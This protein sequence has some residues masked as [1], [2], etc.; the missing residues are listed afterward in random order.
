MTNTL[1]ILSEL[2]ANNQDFEWYPTTDIMIEMVFAAAGDFSSILDIGAGDGRVLERLD[3]LKFERRRKRRIAEGD[4]PEDFFSSIEKYAIE[5]SLVH[6]EKMPP[7]ISIVGTDFNLQVLLDKKVDTIFCNPPYTEYE[8]WATKIIKEANAKDIFLILPDRWK[9]S[10]LIEK[11]VELRGAFSRVIWSGDFM[12]A[13]RQ[14]RARV[15]IIKVC[16]SDTRQ[17]DKTD[18]FHVW[19]DEYFPEFDKIAPHKDDDDDEDEEQEPIQPIVEGQNLIERLAELY[20]A[21]MNNL[22]DNYKKLCEFDMALLKELGVEKDAI[23]QGLRQKIDGL[24]NK[25]WKE[26][27]DHLDKITERLTSGSRNELLSKL[28]ASCN[29]DFS[30]N[31]AYAVVMWVIKNANK[32]IDDQLV[33]IFKKLSEPEHVKN[34]VSNQRTWERGEWRHMRVKKDHTHYTLD[35]R[36]ITKCT[37]AIKTEEY[38]YGSYR[39]NLYED[40]HDLINDIKTIATNLGFRLSPWDHSYSREWESNQAQEF[41]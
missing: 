40:A 18:P 4:E 3:R 15:D 36:I 21:D 19:F 34:Y 6:L 28:R 30:V 32:Y 10:K 22:L 37:H 33:H 23:K 24:K 26:L 31:N 14:A 25:Y 27:F 5:K 8:H 35:Y 17:D 16:I 41:K 2:K 1:Q 12:N 20:T 38:S 11:A 29:I 7:D 9:D 39:N 13:G